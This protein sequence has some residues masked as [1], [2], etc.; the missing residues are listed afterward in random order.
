MLTERIKGIG[1]TIGQI[2]T[3]TIHKTTSLLFSNIMES[4]ES[5]SRR[6]HRTQRM[7]LLRPHPDWDVVEMEEGLV[8]PGAQ[9]AGREELDRNVQGRYSGP[10]VTLQFRRVLS[11]G[12]PGSWV[13]SHQCI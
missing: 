5:R 11:L 7:I 3:Q 4:K 1:E 12:E 8:V 13:I 2:Q 9:G 6:E 10:A